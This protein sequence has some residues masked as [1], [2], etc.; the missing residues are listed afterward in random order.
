MGKVS[1]N[2]AACG[3]LL[4]DW[5]DDEVGDLGRVM[6]KFNLSLAAAWPMTA[7]RRFQLIGLCATH[8][9]PQIYR[10]IDYIREDGGPVRRL[11]HDADSHIDD[12]ADQPPRSAVDR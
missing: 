11:N 5:A 6:A 10:D 7:K 8:S 12:A 1:R 9:P 2:G 3:A 4:G